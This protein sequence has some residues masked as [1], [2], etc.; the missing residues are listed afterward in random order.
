[1][2]S[3]ALGLF[4]IEC[5]YGKIYTFTFH[6]KIVKVISLILKFIIPV[7][8]SLQVA[9]QNI[10]F[11]IGPGREAIKTDRA[12]RYHPGDDTAWASRSLDDSS[13]DTIRSSFQFDERKD[14]NGIAWFRYQINIDDSIKNIPLAFVVE[15]MGTSEIFVDGKRI[16]QFGKVSRTKE[17]EVPLNPQGEPVNFI[18]SQAGEHLIA[19]RYSNHRAEYNL[20]KFNEEFAGFTL[21]IYKSGTATEGYANKT[22]FV[23]FFLALGIG[24]FII[25]ALMHF[26]IFLFY[27]S[28][29]SNLYYSIFTI[30]LAISFVSLLIAENINSPARILSLQLFSDILGVLN[31]LSLLALVYTFTSHGIPKRFWAAVSVGII[32]FIL[33]FTNR[34]WAEYLRIIFFIGS[35][36]EVI[37]VIIVS[38][39]K[40]YDPHKKAKKRVKYIA[41]GLALILIA[42]GFVNIKIPLIILGILL[43]IVVLPVIGSIFIVPV[44]MSIR[45][46][47]TF[48]NTTNSLEAQLKKVKELSAQTL[49]QEKEKQKIIEAQKEVLEIQV[50][51]R[52]A[53][54]SIKNQEITDSINYAKRIQ[55]AI[56]LP[57]DVIKRALPNSFILYKPKDIV[58]G[59]FYW[60]TENE[61]G[62][63]I[64]AADCTG[65]GVPG[66]FMSVISSEK[67]TEAVKFTSNVSELLHQT[68][69]GIKKA[70][71]QTDNE[72]STRD[73]MDIS[74]CLFDKS[75]RSVTYAGANRPLW[76]I[77]KDSGEITEIKPTKSA[78][79]GLT[80]DEQ[81]FESNTLQLNEGDTLYL[82]TD[83]YADQF[84]PTDKKMKT[85]KFKELI[86]SILQK[87]MKEQQKLLDE[88]HEN[89]KGNLEQTDDVL[90]IGVRV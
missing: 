15:H 1:M 69:L 71:R 8:L 73:G 55:S 35:I 18:L 37:R 86:L 88:F 68:N 41:G 27:K 74:V 66:A 21:G 70:L 9:A 83:G 77:R 42:T 90:V 72:S 82:F 22:L 50:A 79:G 38:F 32:Y 20:K 12:W 58:S 19:V 24:V 59:D 85:R 30:T 51:Q 45:H 84:S 60:F 64:A 47:R 48:S 36:I 39:L 53:E 16:C 13:W 26:A 76:L 25:L 7:F 78:I 80:R 11:N 29:R 40:K 28:E 89:W 63:L 87:S 57:L 3:F 43:A 49:E 6:S 10:N 75:F 81:Q 54:L 17:D 33:V 62:Y 4:L 44:Y 2:W 5:A 31:S 52:T 34:S 56:L 65:H 67:L 46:A 14:F 61:N 23:T